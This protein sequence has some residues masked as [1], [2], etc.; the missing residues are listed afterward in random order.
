MLY[1]SV[2]SL[3]F[4]LQVRITNSDLGT[5]LSSQ[6]FATPPYHYLCFFHI[7]VHIAAVMFHTENFS[8][9]LKYMLVIM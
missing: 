2:L 1:M 3:I 5:L 6:E 4:Y 8:H 7:T 9:Y